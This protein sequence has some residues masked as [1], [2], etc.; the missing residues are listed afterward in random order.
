MKAGSIATTPPSSTENMSSAIAPS[1]TWLFHTKRAP[2]AML[3]NT[4]RF[5]AGGPGSSTCRRASTSAASRAN[6][7]A[8][9]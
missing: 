4:G 8:V 9:A 5:T 3:A 7:T 2:C 1:M 6:T